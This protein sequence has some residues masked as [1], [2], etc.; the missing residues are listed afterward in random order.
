MEKQNLW[1]MTKSDGE[2]AAYRIASK[3]M[4]KGTKAALVAILNK[5]GKGDYTEAA[6][7]LLDTE[8][9][10]AM[11]SMLLGYGLTYI[12]KV[13]ADPRAQRLA[14]EFRVE[15]MATA[16]N[17]VIGVALEQFL[18]VITQ[19]MEL[20]PPEAEEETTSKVRIATDAPELKVVVE[21]KEEGKVAATAKA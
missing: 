17:A 11:V 6:S 4:V 13:S 5:Q 20:L 14:E 9:G 21:N 12:P 15:G 16:G 18:P 7:N 8:I 1:A 10:E 19:A 2:N 3:Q